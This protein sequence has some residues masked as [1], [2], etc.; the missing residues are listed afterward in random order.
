L[1]NPKHINLPAGWCANELETGGVELYV[2]NSRRPYFVGV[3][4]PLVAFAAW[5]T[6]ERWN[7]LP[8]NEAHVRFVAVAL[9]ILFAIW[10][11]FA[12]ETW[13]VDRN[14]IEHRVGVKAW[15]YRQHFKDGAMEIVLNHWTRYGAPCFR[16]YVVVEGQ[17]HFLIERD[18]ATLE[19]LA[20]FISSYTTWP[21]K[22]PVDRT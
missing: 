4:S 2:D 10:C 20:A 15:A 1:Q 9:I 17:R 7:S 11:A 12:K 8:R 16:M 19:Q 22:E 13:H 5:N 14:S 3:I 6:Y 18:Q 21:I